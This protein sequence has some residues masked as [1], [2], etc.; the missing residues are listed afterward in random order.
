MSQIVVTVTCNAIIPR[1]VRPGGVIIISCVVSSGGV[2]ISVGVISGCV[3][4]SGGV[5]ISGCVV[6]LSVKKIVS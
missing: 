4:I 6:N 1:G 5:V 2:V 3:V